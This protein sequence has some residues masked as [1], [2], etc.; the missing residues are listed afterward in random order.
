[1]ISQSCLKLRRM[2]SVQCAAQCGRE[3]CAFGKQH[4]NK[5]LLKE[6]IKKALRDCSKII[7]LRERGRGSR[8]ND[9]ACPW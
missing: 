1:M 5:Q 9:H 4:K 8:Q 7:W 2:T 3:A 6:K